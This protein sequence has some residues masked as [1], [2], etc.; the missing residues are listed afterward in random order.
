MAH[1]A[2]EI[3]GCEAGGAAADHSDF[4]P[5]GRQG[6]RRGHNAR[7]VNRHALNAADVDGSIDHIAA[8]G[9]FTGMF[10][11]QRARRREGV[12][13]ADDAHGVGVAFFFNKSYVFGDIDVG[14][15]P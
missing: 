7:V 11:H 14:G 13:V 12:V 3:G 5:G 6:V 15:A 2:Q 9:V 4:F 8:A 1:Q 10:A